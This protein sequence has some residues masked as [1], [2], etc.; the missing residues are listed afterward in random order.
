LTEATLEAVVA[1]SEIESRVSNL[2]RFVEWRRG[3]R[4]S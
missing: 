1:P 2:G 3:V 4:P